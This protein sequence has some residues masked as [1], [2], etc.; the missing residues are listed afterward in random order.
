MSFLS[1]SARQKGIDQMQPIPSSWYWILALSLLAWAVTTLP[2]VIVVGAAA[3]LVFVPLFV[4]FPWLI[5]PIMAALLPISGSYKLGPISA[6]EALLAVAL[7]LWF[8]DGVR[9]R[10]VAIQVSIPLLAGLLYALFLFVALFN[11]YD[12]GEAAAEMLKWVEFAITVV[13]VQTMVRKG[14]RYWLVLG[15]LIG[16]SVQGLIGLYQFLFRI[17]PDWFLFLGRFMRAYGSFSQP[18]PYAGYLGLTLPVA[19]SLALY[20]WQHFRQWK[21]RQI[22]RRTIIDQPIFW[23]GVGVT[24]CGLIGIGMILSWS[25]GGW[26]GMAAGLVMVLFLR[27][28]F[29]IAL[30]T[31]LLLLGLIFALAGA[32]SPTIVPSAITSR[33]ADL[34]AYFGLTDIL[35]QPLTD[36]NFAVVERV[37]HWAAAV[38]MWQL[39]PWLGV[40]P[41]NYAVVYDSVKLPG[42]D[43]ALGHAHNIY[44]NLLAETGIWGLV[45]FLG[46]WGTITGWLI[47]QLRFA[48]KQGDRWQQALL[49][50]ILGAIAH[51]S[52]HNLFDN[53]FV[54]GIY[55]HLALWIGLAANCS[56]GD[57]L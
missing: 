36:E 40:G 20:G 50:G 29:T 15:L 8:G 43:E 14:Q 42:W 3:A 9:R 5:L 26:L 48:K 47:R 22:F 32:I 27:S 6:T 49:L 23:G 45:A 25:R 12:F 51:L 38:R 4:R 41:G 17:G 19:V 2:L 39:S 56:D 24:S 34:P 53:L 28:R 52:V 46:M 44:L 7:F 21:L 11:A 10:S 13:L 30:G 18:N 57:R 55:L 16:G 33:L 37:A 1:Q 54:Q 31:L 35:S